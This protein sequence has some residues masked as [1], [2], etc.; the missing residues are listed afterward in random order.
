MDTLAGLVWAFDISTR[1]TLDDGHIFARINPADGFPDGVTID[2]EGC[3][4]VALWGGWAVRRYSPAGELLASIAMPCSQVTKIAFGGSDL[5]TAFV[6][7][8]RI[9]LSADELL[10]QPDAGGLFT[11]RAPASGLPSN[12]VRLR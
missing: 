2:S 11:F 12:L 5:R 8:A 10:Q 6:T 7:S 9:G 1:D 4:W 3:L